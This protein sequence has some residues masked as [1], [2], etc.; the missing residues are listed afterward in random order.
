MGVPFV[1]WPG[2]ALVSR[3][4]RIILK[5]VG[6][7]EL[8]ADTPEAYVDI[9]VALSRDLPRLKALRA[10]LRERMQASSLMDAPRFAR[11]LERAFRGMWRRWT[12]VGAA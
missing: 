5:N 1:T 12:N 10:N 3:M 11:N 7:D 6:L 4:G 2:D 8:I 9:A